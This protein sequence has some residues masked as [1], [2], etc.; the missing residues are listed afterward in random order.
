VPRSP[1]PPTLAERPFAV[2]EALAHG[3]GPGRLRGPDLHR[4]HHGVRLSVSGAGPPPRDL[5]APDVDDT[6]LGGTVHP[7]VVAQARG[8]APVL[9]PGQ[10]FSHATALA[11]WGLPVPSEV[12][13]GLAA[14]HV[15]TVDGRGM[16]RP[17][18][19]GHRVRG[20]VEIG[21]APG[22]PVVDPVSAW[23]Q[24]AAVLGLDE[25]VRVG[26]A[27]CGVWSP[28]EEARG[29]QPNLLAATVGALRGV[30]GLA[31]LRDALGLVRAGVRSP[32]ETDVRLLLVR[33]GL[34]EPEINVPTVD[35]AGRF[36]GVPDLRWLRQKVAVEY[37]GDAHRRDPRRFRRDIT[38]RERF[39]DDGW[40]LVRCTDDDLHGAAARDFVAR[41]A[42]RLA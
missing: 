16:R 27:L 39:A 29:R 5:V 34:E 2:A 14:L 33:A 20:P 40:T 41:V 12:Q 3:V 35:A 21:Q 18:V 28:F 42:R 4:P 31:S 22:V 23:V 13:R 10:H 24:S 11:L 7:G 19:T 25:L 8:L 37:E 6:D 32:K 26:D 30:R 15:S 17:G 36:L 38:R 1:L 9:R